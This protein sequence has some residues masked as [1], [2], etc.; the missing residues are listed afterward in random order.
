MTDNLPEPAYIAG[1]ATS[2]RIHHPDALQAAEDEL[3]HTRQLALVVANWINNPNY[4]LAARTALAEVL[5]LPEPR[6]TT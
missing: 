1:L 3:A 4:D 5:G 6:R 2:L